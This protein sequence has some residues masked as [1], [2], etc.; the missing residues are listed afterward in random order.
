MIDY[1]INKNK[2]FINNDIELIKQQI[3]ILFDTTPGEVL[4]Q[5]TFGTQYDKYLYNLK[6]SNEGL[7]SEVLS[8]LNS[9][10]LFGFHPEVDVYLLQGTEQ[11]IALI[12]IKLSRDGEKYEKIY[13]IS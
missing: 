7:R 9:L 8:D 4:G 5:E 2:S 1:S 12:D 10:E 11:D 3:D 13:K 6:I